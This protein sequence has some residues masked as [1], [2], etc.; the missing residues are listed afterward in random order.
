MLLNNEKQCVKIYNVIKYSYKLV[1]KNCYYILKEKAMKKKILS[2][3]V[4]ATM[5]FGCIA[6]SMAATKDTVTSVGAWGDS[7]GTETITGNFDVTYTFH[8]AT[9]YSD[10]DS[11]KALKSNFDTFGIEIRDVA[12]TGCFDLRP[13]VYGWWWGTWSTDQT[14]NL[15]DWANWTITDNDSLAG[16]NMINWDDWKATFISADVT[17]NLKRTDNIIAIMM[18]VAGDNGI[19]YNL[20]QSVASSVT[21]ANDLTSCII[22]PSENATATIKLTNLKF[23]DNKEV[24]D[25]TG[26]TT[27]GS[28]DSGN[29]NETTAVKDNNDDKNL[30][31]DGNPDSGDNSQTSS[32]KENTDKNPSASETNAADTKD[33]AKKIEDSAKIEGLD[34]VKLKVNVIAKDDKAFKAVD[35]Y[36]VKNFADAAKTGKYAFVELNL[37]DA[38]G[39]KLSQLNKA[40]KVTLNAKDFKALEGVTAN[41][42]ITVYRVSDDGK[43]IQFL[44]TATVAA[45]GTFS[46]ETDHFSKYLFAAGAPAENG[47]DTTTGDMNTMILIAVAFALAAVGAGIVA[48]RS[49]KKVEE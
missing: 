33:D 42:K 28:P 24:A 11:A 49:R 36:V 4:A 16:T 34:D 44:G 6:T 25:T 3:L 40:V 22:V 38:Q 30:P 9:T 17:I 7:S 15:G 27:N 39:T 20:A 5:T 18:V 46:F 10:D 8:T 12:N 45:D 13:D 19:T 1:I 2:I 26:E 35:E 14:Y 32:V 23:V 43:E 29:A 41:D 48:L 31:T 21:L 47:S 37:L